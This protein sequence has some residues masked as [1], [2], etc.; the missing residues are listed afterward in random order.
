MKVHPF[1]FLWPFRWPVRQYVCILCFGVK[2]L[3]SS[4]CIHSETLEGRQQIEKYGTPICVEGLFWKMFVTRSNNC[5]IVI[6]TSPFL[7]LYG[8]LEGQEASSDPKLCD[9][10]PGTGKRAKVNHWQGKVDSITRK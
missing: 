9:T 1:I 5:Y 10:R 2:C 7:D 6:H 4:R 8:E 3:F